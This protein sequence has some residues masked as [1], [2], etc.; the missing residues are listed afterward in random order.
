MIYSIVFHPAAEQ[1]YRENFVYY[2]NHLE[3]L[4]L[5]FEADVENI[6]HKISK[7]PEMFGIDH[8]NYRQTILPNFPFVIVFKLNKKKKQVYIAAIHHTKRNPKSKYRKF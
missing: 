5:R 6:I 2:E 8:K 7:H 3:G 1:E 4:G